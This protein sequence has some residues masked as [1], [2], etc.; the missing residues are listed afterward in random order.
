MTQ[1]QHVSSSMNHNINVNINIKRELQDKGYC[2]I[3]NVL[4]P[5]EVSNALMM[6]KDW[7]KTIPNHDIL[8]NKI[9]PH[10]I[11]KRHEASHQDF[12]WYIKTNKNVQNIFKYLWNTDDLIVSFDGSCYI[13]KNC[14][15]KDDV[16][17]HTDQASG[18]IGLYCYQ[19]L[20]ALTS[21]KE[22]TLVVY[23]GTHNYH[24]QYFKERGISNDN[25][26]NL[27]DHDVL[28]RADIKSK[29]HALNI[30]SGSLVLWDSRVFHQNR[31]GKP[32]SEERIVQYVC[33]FPKTHPKNTE[34]MKV[35]RRK[36]FEERRNTSH[37]PAPINVVSLQP[38]TFGDDDLLIDYS[39]LR[40]PNLDQFMNEI[41]KLL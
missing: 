18:R 27:I 13:P 8:H 40:K 34:A 15:K 28:E 33:Y 2:I 21:N 5:G 36:Y 16:W 9:D 19:G 12:A 6:F 25:N 26:W 17:T 3:P 22:R 29:K 39:K 30:P 14:T 24:E 23:E 38:R 20:V 1:L 10:G 37:W 4:S 35:K 31:Y 32:N 11:Y 7:Q 41:E